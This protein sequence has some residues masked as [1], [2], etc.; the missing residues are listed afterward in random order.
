MK[1]LAKH[2]GIAV[3][4]LA[5]LNREFYRRTDS[6]PSRSDLRKSGTLEQDAGWHSFYTEYYG[7]EDALLPREA[8]LILSKSRNGPLRAVH[9]QLVLA[10]LQVGE[11]KL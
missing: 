4:L 1:D 6:R 3:L 10:N 9:L 11:H 7:C 5:Q 2:M 8:K